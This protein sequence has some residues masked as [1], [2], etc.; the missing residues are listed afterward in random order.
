MKYENKQSYNCTH[1]D[2]SEC[3]ALQDLL[4]AT[5]HELDVCTKRV[6]T[7]KVEHGYFTI[8]ICGKSIAFSLGGPQAEALFEFIKHISAENAYEVDID[9]QT[10]DG[11][12]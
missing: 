2:Y 12:Y 8:S 3:L 9:K 4:Q 7:G 10:V 6:D 11:W 1:D 5:W